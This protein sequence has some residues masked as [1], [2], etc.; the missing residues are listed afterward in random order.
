M[1]AYM[2][3]LG[4]VENMGLFACIS[5]QASTISCAAMFT[6]F[7]QSCSRGGIFLRMSRTLKQPIIIRRFPG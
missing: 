3:Y 7:D 2:R 4:F 6:D 1:L 5:R